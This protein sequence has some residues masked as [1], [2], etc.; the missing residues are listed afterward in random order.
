MNGGAKHGDEAWWGRGIFRIAAGSVSTLLK[1]GSDL[2][3]PESGL[4]ITAGK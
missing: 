3:E 2:S 4:E 1:G